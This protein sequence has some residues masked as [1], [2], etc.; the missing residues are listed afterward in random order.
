MDMRGEKRRAS[1]PIALPRFPCF[2]WKVRSSDISSRAAHES[3][4]AGRGCK[5]ICEGTV[6]RIALPR[7][8]PGANRDAIRHKSEREKSQGGTV[9][10]YVGGRR[11]ERINKTERGRCAMAQR[12]G[13]RIRKGQGLQNKPQS[14]ILTAE[15]DK[16][17]SRFICL[18]RCRV[19][20][21]H[22]SFMQKQKS[23]VA[24][25]C[26]ISVI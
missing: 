19:Y 20:I 4:L 8:S 3:D 6:E 26:N 2:C 21:K 13:R 18:A 22:C 11:G 9:R 25:S 16:K 7:P 15:L 5:W 24:F 1:H 12:G 23:K 14:L 17:T 10:M